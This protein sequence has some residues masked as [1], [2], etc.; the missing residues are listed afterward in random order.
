MVNQRSQSVNNISNKRLLNY[1][2]NYLLVLYRNKSIFQI[3]IWNI[4]DEHK[5]KISKKCLC[6]TKGVITIMQKVKNK[7]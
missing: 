6:I 3:K 5:L 4:M 2:S 1:Q 7:K